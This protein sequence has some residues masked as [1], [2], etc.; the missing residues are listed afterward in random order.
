MGCSPPCSPQSGAAPAAVWVANGSPLGVWPSAENDL[1][2][3]AATQA[4][5][6]L[7]LIVSAPALVLDQDRS[8]AT[9]LM[10]AAIEPSK[11]R[12]QPAMDSVNPAIDNEDS[13]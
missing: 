11:V 12:A 13:G 8:L 2:G 9:V 3:D 7:S 10:V 4:G 6:T 5:R 1:A